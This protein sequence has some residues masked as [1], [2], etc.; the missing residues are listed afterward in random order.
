M[1]N[2]LLELAAKPLMNA[3]GTNTAQRRAIA[4]MG[5]VTSLIA[6]RPSSGSAR[7][8]IA[9]N[10]PLRRWRHPPRCRPPHKAKRR[11]FMKAE[12]GIAAHAA[13]ET[14]PPPSGMIEARHV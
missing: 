14:A 13:N 7:V 1:A 12:G 3:V 4:M 9:F 2:C 11:L 6:L 5:P 8:D 10:I